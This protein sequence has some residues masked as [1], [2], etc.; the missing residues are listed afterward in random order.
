MTTR[1]NFMTDFAG[2]DR[3]ST[4]A[5]L[6]GTSIRARLFSIFSSLAVAVGCGDQAATG[7]K[8]MS[9]FVFKRQALINKVAA[10]IGWVASAAVGL[11]AGA[12]V[13][14]MIGG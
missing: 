11:G 2:S 5:H 4:K 13:F 12:L 10:R 1:K 14:R 3:R 7:F 8:A 9:R 6:Q